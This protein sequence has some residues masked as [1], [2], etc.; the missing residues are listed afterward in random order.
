MIADF[1]PRFQRQ[2]DA[3]LG[4]GTPYGAIAQAGIGAIQSI[5]GLIQAK[6]AQKQLER[7]QSPTYKQSAGILDFYQKALAKYNVNPYQTDFFRMQEKLADRGVTSGVGMLQQR[8]SALAGISNLIQG[9]QDALQKAGATAEQIQQQNLSQLGQAS[10]LKRQEEA[11]AFDINQMQPFERKFNLLAAKAAGGNQILNAGMANVFGGAQG[12]TDL[13]IAKQI[14]SSKQPPTTLPVDVTGTTA[15][16]Y[17]RYNPP[18]RTNLLQYRS[19]L[20]NG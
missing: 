11:A 2:L 12:I 1:S 17:F 9:R 6:R 16:E 19:R 18:N 3:A 4:G 5:A 13:Q 7:L 8:G 14:Y 15:Q 10:Q 20:L